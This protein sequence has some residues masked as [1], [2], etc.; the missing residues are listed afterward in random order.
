MAAQSLVNGVKL[1]VR[2]FAADP[3]LNVVIGVNIDSLITF[4]GRVV[5]QICLVAAD[6]QLN[7]SL[8]G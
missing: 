3:Q 1:L 2:M 5:L 4:V 8:L 7:R 6:P